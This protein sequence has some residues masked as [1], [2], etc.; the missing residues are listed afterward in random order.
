MKNIKML[1]FDRID[2]FEGIDV[3]KTSKSKECYICHYWYFLNKEF[4]FQPY[5]CNRC[6]DLLKMSVN[7]SNIAILK[8]KNADYHLII[9]EIS[10]IDATELLQNIDLAE[11]SEIS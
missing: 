3:N 1:Y 11:K 2:V 7:L 5:V 6:H 9:V 8:T 10:K 4:K